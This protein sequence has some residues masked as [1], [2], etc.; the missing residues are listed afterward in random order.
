MQLR[1]CALVFLSLLAT[2]CHAGLGP[3]IA[4][5]FD[6]GARIGWEASGGWAVARASVGQAFSLGTGKDTDYYA[7]AEPGALVGAT[8]G[9]DHAAGGH[10]QMMSGVWLGAP[11]YPLGDGVNYRWNGMDPVLTLAIGYRYA[12][13]HELYF[14]PKGYLL[15]HVQFFH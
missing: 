14:A 4:Y 7:A 13:G 8:F 11:V 12:H 3:V 1:S 2:S 10:N 6:D 15:E 5:R 9:F